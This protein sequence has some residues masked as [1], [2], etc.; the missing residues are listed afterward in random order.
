MS[1]EGVVRKWKGMDFHI[2]M[3]WCILKAQYISVQRTE[4]R[5]SI[6]YRAIGRSPSHQ[7]LHAA[8]DESELFFFLGHGS[9]MGHPLL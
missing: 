6:S 5:Y 4:R 7:D 3:G 1:F 2:F 9:S 8:L